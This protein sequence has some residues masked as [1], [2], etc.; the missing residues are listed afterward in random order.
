MQRHKRDWT[1][2][3]ATVCGIGLFPVAPGTAGSAAGLAAVWGLER[4]TGGWGVAVAL[5]IC[6]PAGV[7]AAE[8]VAAALKQTDPQVIV[9]DEVCGMM[10]TLAALPLTPMTASA[11]FL[12]F[13][14]FDILKPFPICWVERRW[15]GGA[16]VMA[17]DLLA[18]LAANVCLRLLFA[19]WT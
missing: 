11:G 7:A 16:G 2:W 17:D 12:L 14:G 1:W 4:W 15:P 13:R 5:I 8:G 6:I 10:V 9:I 3:V 18:G 19:W